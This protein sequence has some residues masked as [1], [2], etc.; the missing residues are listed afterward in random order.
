MAEL[1]RCRPLRYLVIVVA[2]V[3][4]LL[5]HHHLLLLLLLFAPRPAR[6]PLS[7]PLLSLPKRLLLLHIEL[8]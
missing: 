8:S 3:V 6:V 5:F 1:S 2:V 7:L 4:L